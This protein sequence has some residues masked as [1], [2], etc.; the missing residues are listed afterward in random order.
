MMEVHPY[1]PLMAQK[2]DKGVKEGKNLKVQTCMV[3]PDH[4][5]FNMGCKLQNA[6]FCVFIFLVYK[7]VNY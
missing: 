6:R 7:L 3:Q 5:Q 2:E 1:N 4:A